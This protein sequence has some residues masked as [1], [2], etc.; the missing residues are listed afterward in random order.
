MCPHLLLQLVQGGPHRLCL[1]G[2]ALL[3]L[4]PLL[5]LCQLMLHIRQRRHRALQLKHLH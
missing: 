5:Q 2:Q 4:Q 3:L 1:L